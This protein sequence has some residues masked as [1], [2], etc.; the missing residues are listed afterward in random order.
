MQHRAALDQHLAELGT[1][2]YERDYL[3]ADAR[4]RLRAVEAGQLEVVVDRVLC[5]DAVEV[6]VDGKLELSVAALAHTVRLH[7]ALPRG[8]LERLVQIEHHLLDDDV[9]LLLYGLV[10]GAHKRVPFV[11]VAA[12][13]RRVLECGFVAHLNVNVEF[14]FFS[15]F[16]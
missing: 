12:R 7:G 6:N 11:R 4:Q 1:R 9:Q 3:L 2:V 14:L 15:L 8:I 16:N 5:V 10:A 13:V